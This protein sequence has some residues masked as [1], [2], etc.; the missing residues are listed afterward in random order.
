[1]CKGQSIDH[2]L[3]SG[4][5]AE[6]EK[7][8]NY[9]T[10]NM[11]EAFLPPFWAISLSFFCI[12][13][14]IRGGWSCQRCVQSSIMNH[15]T[16]KIR[17]DEMLMPVSYLFKKAIENRHRKMKF[18]PYVVNMA[19]HLSEFFQ[20]F[21]SHRFVVICQGSN[22]TFCMPRPGPSGAALNGCQLFICCGP[23]NHS[24]LTKFW[25]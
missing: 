6:R 21:C 15:H 8:L 25:L 14:F 23:T 5:S 20:I 13:P 17:G 1:M 4:V 24:E 10:A 9:S 7:G 11:T 12:F 16:C 2:R 22:R 19:E 3:F 18:S